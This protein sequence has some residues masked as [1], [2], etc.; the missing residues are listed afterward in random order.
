MVYFTNTFLKHLGVIEFI[1]K[2]A[3]FSLFTWTANFSV[4]LLLLFLVWRL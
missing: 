3:F 4:T 2:P 1:R